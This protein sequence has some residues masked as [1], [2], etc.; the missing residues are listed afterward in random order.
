MVW[1]IVS[2]S[3]LKVLCQTAYDTKKHYILYGQNLGRFIAHAFSVATIPDV[4]AP[5]VFLPKCELIPP[6]LYIKEKL[7]DKYFIF[8]KY[9]YIVL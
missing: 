6:F 9:S 3:W 1:P 5:V 4:T 2:F 7:I 8:N